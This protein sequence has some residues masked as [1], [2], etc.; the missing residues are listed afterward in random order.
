MAFTWQSILLTCG[1]A[2]A[3][4]ACAPSAASGAV[5]QPGIYPYLNATSVGVDANDQSV[6]IGS[7]TWQDRLLLQETA[8][9]ESW[10]MMIRD[11][12]VVYPKKNEVGYKISCIK[13]LD[14]RRD[15]KNGE[16]KVKEGG[17]SYNHVLLRFHSQRN[18]GLN[19][20]VQVY[21][22]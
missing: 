20:L 16:V 8:Y 18:H 22:H 17:V 12:D 2:L 14:Q 5:L 7:T 19:Y 15:G 3:V 4:L 11:A 21:G 9:K 1:A 6:I 10:W 13:I